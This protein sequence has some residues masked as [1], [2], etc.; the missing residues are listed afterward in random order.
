MKLVD[1][2]IKRET[3][4]DQLNTKL[5]NLK[6]GNVEDGRNNKK[7]QFVN[8]L[9]VSWERKLSLRQGIL[10]KKLYIL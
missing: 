1:S 4:Q 8:L 5:E 6:F 3:F 10:V 2:R 7:K 9:M